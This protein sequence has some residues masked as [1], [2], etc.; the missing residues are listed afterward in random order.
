MNVF[1]A[2]VNLELIRMLERFIST[3]NLVPVVGAVIARSWHANIAI[4]FF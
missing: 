1:G 3:W 2:R 4:E